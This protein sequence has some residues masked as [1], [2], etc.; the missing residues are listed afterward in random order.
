MIVRALADVPHP[1]GPSAVTIGNFD[2]V[3]Y[4][5]RYLMQRVVAIGREHGW[6]STVLTFDPHPAR[7]L[8]PDRA[9]RLLSTPGERIELMREQGI[10]RI[11]I[12]PFT[13]EI[14]KLTPEEF[15][16]QILVDKLQARAVLVGD[17]FRFGNRAAGDINTLRDFGSRYGFDVIAVSRVCLRGRV[18][19]STEVR[20][21]LQAGNVS[22]VCRMLGRPFTLRGK[23]I[24]GEGIGHTQTV[25][26]LNLATDSEVLPASGVYITRTFDPETG[27]TWHSI[28]NV[29]Y[30]PTFG[31][32]KLTIET[33]L[34]S[35]FEGPPPQTIALDFLKRVRDERKFDS[36]AALKVQI[37]KDV[38]R[39]QTYFRRTAPQP[40]RA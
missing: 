23:I 10:E 26:T 11:V 1:F 2:G 22:L 24:K 7:L 6:V 14:S 15:V 25:P 27:H 32:E 3:H 34:L 40:Q 21:Q 19:S 31:G 17:N 29:G 37:L 4:G 9:P 33:F 30:R 18:V 35:R 39:A 8:A 38:Q 36:A 16:E 12:L 20:R 28:T 5:H 13:H